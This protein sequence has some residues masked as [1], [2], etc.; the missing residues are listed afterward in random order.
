MEKRIVE[1]DKYIIY[2]EDK[3]ILTF[4]TSNSKGIN[5]ISIP[6]LVKKGYNIDSTG[7]FYRYIVQKLL[8][9]EDVC[10]LGSSSYEIEVFSTKNGKLKKEILKVIKNYYSYYKEFTKDDYELV[11]KLCHQ[12]H[13]LPDFFTFEE[14]R[15]LFLHN[16]RKKIDMNLEQPLEELQKRLDFKIY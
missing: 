16:E 14:L 11:I 7:E 8:L 3:K 10:F 6:N 4:T 2:N 15:H 13:V 1:K 5:H 12:N 9:N